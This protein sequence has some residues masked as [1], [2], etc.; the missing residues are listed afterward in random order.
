MMKVNA[1]SDCRTCRTLTRLV[2]RPDEVGKKV[3]QKHLEII[4]LCIADHLRP[5][6]FLGLVRPRYG[7]RIG[8]RCVKVA[9]NIALQD[10]T[11]NVQ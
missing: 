9:Q 5:T 11:N 6:L 8:P 2:T 1:Q 4:F 3:S 10:H 7:P